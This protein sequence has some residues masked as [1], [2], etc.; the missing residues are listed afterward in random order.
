M[1]TIKQLSLETINKIAAGEVIQQP[2]SALKELIENSL[3]AKSSSISIELRDGGM[4]LLHIS[5]TGAGIHVSDY[6]ILCHRFTT[7]KISQ[8]EDL[9]NLN[10]FGFRGE[11]LSS[12]SLISKVTVISRKNTEAIGFKAEYDK[13]ELVGRPEPY[14]LDKGTQIIIRDLF[15]NNPCRR[16]A[17]CNFGPLFRSCFDVTVKYALHYRDV[18]FMLKSENTVFR[19]NGKSGYLDIF[20]ALLKNS[21]IRDIEFSEV[22]KREKEFCKFSG[23]VS[24]CK[25]TLK[26][27]ELVLFI[28]GRLVESPELTSLLKNVYNQFHP[29]YVSYFVYLSIELN[30]KAIDVNVHPCKQVV[31]FRNQVEIFTEIQQAITEVL[32]QSNSSKVIPFKEIEVSQLPRKPAPKTQIRETPSVPLEWFIE[33]KPLQS[34]KEPEEHLDSIQQLTQEISSGDSQ[35][36][37]NNSIFIGCLS[38]TNSL[39]QYKNELYMIDMQRLLMCM[40]YQDILENFSRFPSFQIVSS[41][42]LISDLLNIA[43]KNT[44]LYDPDTDPPTHVL[45]EKFT[46]LIGSKADML[47]DYFS[48]RIQDGKICEIP[49]VVSQLLV[50]DIN[51]LPEFIL[52]LCADVCWKNEKNCLHKICELLAWFY[53]KVPDSWQVTENCFDYEYHYKNTLFPYLRGRV[54]TDPRYLALN[55]GLHRIVSTVELYSIFERC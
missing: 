20:K 17:L 22:T 32:S 24:N 35:D 29:K 8:Y 30:P 4:T 39:I 49:V 7:S 52:R 46:A 13:G 42:L 45:T 55:N 36:I 34:L 53:S 25:Y 48:I 40:T 43:F 12:I 28:N 31:K 14:A 44:D 51:N 19:A 16:K 18:E 23:I 50:P 37:L 54:K 38:K 5:D 9:W 3:D 47:L 21:D 6:P 10:T 11:A 41:D 2:S 15:F 27:K 1:S 33:Q 26:T